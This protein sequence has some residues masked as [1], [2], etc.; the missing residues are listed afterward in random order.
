MHFEKTVEIDAPVDVVWRAVTDVED[1][2]KWTKSVRKIAWLDGRTLSLGARARIKQPGMPSLVWKVTE[3][4]PGKSFT[5]ES[6]R[7]GVKTVATHVLE[8]ID[9]QRTELVV[10][11]R[12]SGPLSSV[13]SRLIAH[14]METYL[15]MEA[16]GLRERSLQDQP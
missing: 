15:R 5:W 6:S 13:L 8:R 12:L 1:W 4:V 2:P 9:D 10:G 16:E 14:R 7:P 3:L 11:S